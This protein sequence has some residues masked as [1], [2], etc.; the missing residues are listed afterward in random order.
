MPRTLPEIKIIVTSMP[1]LSKILASLAT[2]RTEDEPGVVEIYEVFNLSAAVDRCA[3][4]QKNVI[5]NVATRRQCFRLIHDLRV[6]CQYGT[7]QTKL[8]QSCTWSKDS[9]R[10]VDFA[11]DFNFNHSR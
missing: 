2:H 1:C 8:Q 11:M 7:M 3:A 9:C 6:S 10:R 4:N 5:A